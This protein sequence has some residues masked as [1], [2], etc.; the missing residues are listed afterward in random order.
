MP[1][2]TRL[3]ALALLPLLLLAACATPTPTSDATSASIAAAPTAARPSLLLV[4]LDGLRPDALG[5]GDTPNL[6]A[7][8]A[9]GVRAWMRPSYPSLT[10]P[11]HYTLV[12]GL[13]PDR[14]GLIH[15]SMYDDMLGEFRLSDRAAVGNGA[16]YGDGEPLWVTA[17]NAG[18]RTATLS[19]PGSEAPVRGVQ[20][21]RWLPFDYARP[22]DARVDL[23][24]DWLS[25]PDA[26]RPV[27]ATL[28]FEHTDAAG[29]HYGPDSV[30]LHQ[31]L[32]D[33]DAAVGRLVDGLQARGL[34]D[35]VNLVFVSD[36][37]MA[38]VAPGRAIAIEDMVSV[39]AARV[40]STGQVIGVIPNPGFEAQVARRLLGAHAQYD[41]WRKEAMPARWKFGTHPRVPPIVCQLHEGWD[42]VPRASLATRP[43]HAR[44][45]HG[46][47]PALPSMRAVFLAHGPAFRQGVELPGFDNVDVY[48]LLA[49]LIGVTPAEHDGDAATLLP[50]LRESDAE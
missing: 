35:R 17:E 10:F 4:S 9:D 28:Y 12:T 40:V 49:R 41:C 3:R 11:N 32:R 6:D 20:P 44:G 1:D 8:A 25:E 46:Y 48:P 24:L 34:E 19:W 36:H 22:I 42:A 39:E 33:V 26:T 5:R 29:H 27:L 14:H 50:A 38:E 2:R 21:T 47:D 45:S 31:A 37:G 7:L 15:N 18:L 43:S 13:R 23:V 30:E 16:W